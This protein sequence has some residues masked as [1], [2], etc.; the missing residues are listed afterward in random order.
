[1]HSIFSVSYDPPLGV[2]KISGEL[3]LMSR[4]QLAWRLVHLDAVDCRTFRLDLGQVT[5]I[6]AA[7]LRLIDEARRRVIGRG[8]TFELTSASRCFAL[9]SGLA[10]YR[11]LA[12]QAERLTADVGPPTDLVR[13]TD[14]PGGS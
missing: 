10:G 1:M 6:D 14:R 9:V 8:G 12:A 7:C 3:D 11:D 5:F 4:G 13:L 2:M